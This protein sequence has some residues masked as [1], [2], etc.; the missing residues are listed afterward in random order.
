MTGTG[1][2]LQRFH[3]IENAIATVPEDKREYVRELLLSAR[4]A[5]AVARVLLSHGHQISPST[6]RTYRRMMRQTGDTE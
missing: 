2:A 4:A 6:I 5:E 1:P 3:S